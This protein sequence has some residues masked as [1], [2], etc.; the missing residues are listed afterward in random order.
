M[1]LTIPANITPLSGHDSFETSYEVADYPYGGYRTVVR[2][3][4]EYKAKHGQRVMFCSRNPKT[5]QWNKPK[6]ST[7]SQLICMFLNNDNGHIE[8]AHIGSVWDTKENFDLFEKTFESVM[9][10]KQKSDIKALRALNIA[11]SPRYYYDL[12]EE[13]MPAYMEG[14]E[15]ITREIPVPAKDENNPEVMEQRKAGFARRREARELLVESIKTK[16]A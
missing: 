3:W 6:A 5:L 13:E 11:Q 1:K 12:K 16:R 7:Y 14:I 15:I 9:T 10:E 2:Y 4:V 8:F